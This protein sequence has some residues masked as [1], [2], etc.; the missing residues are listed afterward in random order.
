[1]TIYVTNNFGDFDYDKEMAKLVKTLNDA[2]DHVNSL[3]HWPRNGK[4]V[5]AIYPQFHIL[6]LDIALLEHNGYST[7]GFTDYALALEALKRFPFV[8]DAVLWAKADNARQRIG[9]VSDTAFYH[10][11][12]DVHPNLRI[13]SDLQQ[14]LN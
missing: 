7:I 3:A 14:L 11:L 5:M 4:V 2:I 9:Y 13:V 6:Q 1:M 8:P 12:L 10:A